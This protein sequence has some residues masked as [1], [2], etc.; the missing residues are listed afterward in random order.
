MIVIYGKNTVGKGVAALCDYL[1]LSY[2][3]Y[4]DSDAPES[5]EQYDIIIPSPGIPGTHRIYETGKVVS[6]M[7]FVASYLPKGITLLA[8]TGTD[9][10]S[11]T[12][13]ILYSILQKV[14]F[15]KKSV[16]I[17]GNFGTPFSETAKEILQKN[18]TN[19]IVVLEVSSFMSYWIGKSTFPACMMDMTIITNLKVDHLNW[20]RNVQEYSDAKMNLAAHTKQGVVMNAQIGQFLAE[21]GVHMPDIQ[22]TVF[23]FSDNQEKT[24]KNYTDGEN[25][26][27]N[28]E[29][30]CCL[31]DTQFSG[32]HNAM[33]FLSVSM[34]LGKMGISI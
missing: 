4:D 16:Y 17:S 29:H 7:D 11:T 5:F 32:K 30:V 10:K 13:W 20:H 31:S 18:E 23:T 33:N 22:T 2:E 1:G 15:G 19:A 28:G 27:V 14:F 8:V 9:G 21:S 6:E 25:I 24:P 26:I 34:V 3:M 12:T